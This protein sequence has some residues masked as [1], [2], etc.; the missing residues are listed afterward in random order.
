M[1]IE[2]GIVDLKEGSIGIRGEME[3]GRES[4]GLPTTKDGEIKDG[5]NQRNEPRPVNK[6]I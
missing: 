1:V 6:A 3:R 4:C 5:V 2:E